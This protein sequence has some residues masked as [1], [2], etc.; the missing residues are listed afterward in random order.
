MENKFWAEIIVLRCQEIILSTFKK[1]DPT[2]YSHKIDYLD[3]R[4]AYLGNRM[5]IVKKKFLRSNNC[6]QVPISYLVKF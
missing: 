6:P 5:N 4:A 2:H 1:S 3:S